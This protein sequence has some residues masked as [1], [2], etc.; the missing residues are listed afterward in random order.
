MVGYIVKGLFLMLRKYYE[1]FYKETQTF[2]E[3]YITGKRKKD[4]RAIPTSNKDDSTHNTSLTL[5]SDVSNI[6][7]LICKANASTPS[8]YEINR[9]VKS[10]KKSD[11]TILDEII[12]KS[13]R[14]FSQKEK[15]ESEKIDIDAKMGADIDYNRDLFSNYIDFDLKLIEENKLSNQIAEEEYKHEDLNRQLDEVEEVKVDEERLDKIE[16]KERF[17]LTLN[18]LTLLNRTYQG[19]LQQVKPKANNNLTF[20]SEISID[21]KDYIKE[22]KQKREM[23]PKVRVFEKHFN[24]LIMDKS[25]IVFKNGLDNDIKIADLKIDSFDEEIR[26]EIYREGEES[27]SNDATIEKFR[28]QRLSTNRKS[29]DPSNRLSNISLEEVFESTNKKLLTRKSLFMN[30]IGNV[31]LE[32]DSNFNI[33]TLSYNLRNNLQT[34]LNLEFHEIGENEQEQDENPGDEVYKY[35]CETYRAGSIKQFDITNILPEEI[36]KTSEPKEATAIAFYSLLINAQNNDINIT[37]ENPF[38]DIV[39]C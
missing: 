14:K 29:I 19:V 15:Q 6:A 18:D 21:V 1:A 17:E 10:M 22:S 28:D 3:I 39:L 31:I 25:M 9:L 8:K 30:D 34:N 23:E 38:G 37:Q 35:I 26:Q 33:N 32:E 20:D 11:S 12:E 5:L 7:Q 16:K 27:K 2:I 13:T 24:K 4:K 36:I